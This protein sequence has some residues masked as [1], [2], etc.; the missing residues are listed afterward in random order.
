MKKAYNLEELENLIGKETVEKCFT[1]YMMTLIGQ[2]KR[3]EDLQNGRAVMEEDELERFAEK[4]SGKE[5]G[6]VQAVLAALGYDERWIRSDLI[7]AL[8]KN[9]Q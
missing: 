5:T 8:T 7:K 4:V 3:A 9:R 1:E 2:A 6:T